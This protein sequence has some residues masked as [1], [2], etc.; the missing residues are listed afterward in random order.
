MLSPALLIFVCFLYMVFLAVVAGWAERR[1]ASGKDPCNNPIIYALSLTVY[2]TAW[3]FY[4]SVGKAASAGM[5]FL[6]IYLGPTLA[7]ILWWL[8]LR[9]MVRIKEAYRVTSIADFI[10]LRY[11][12]ST[13]V[14]ALVTVID[15]FAVIPYF[16]LQLQAMMTTFALV[17]RSAGAYWVDL[18]VGL[19]ISVLVIAFTIV[20]GVRRL[21]PTERHQ[22]MVVAMTVA[23]LVKLVPLL[24]VGGYVTYVLFGGMEDLFSRFAVSPVGAS[25]GNTQ[26]SPSSYVSWFSFLL[27]SMSAV[28]F[29][30]RQFHMAVVENMNEKHILTA[31]WLFPLYMLVMNFFLLPITMGGLLAGFPVPEADSFVLL[32]P[33]ANGQT[34]LS[35]LAFVGGV[36]AATGMIMVGSMTVSTM[37]A[38]HLMLPV[39]ESLP[40]LAIVK[41]Y[42]LQCRWLSVSF[43]VLA[44]YWF[45]GVVGKYL[46]LVDIGILS[47]AAIL[48]YAPAMVGALF[49][50]KGNKAGALLGM[51]AGFLL[52]FY[53]LIVPALTR[54][55]VLPTSILQDGPWGVA[56]LRPEQLFGLSGFDPASHATLWTMLFNVSLYVLGSLYF[57]Q[58]VEERNVAEQFVTILGAASIA[59]PRSGEATVD[60]A[61]KSDEIAELYCQYFPKEKAE[62]LMTQSLRDLELENKES[63]SLAELAELY[64][65]AEIRLAG[66]IGAAAAYNAF[67]KSRIISP[68]EQKTLQ[69]VY[70]DILS[71]LR[72]APS[73]LKKRVDYHREREKLL[74]QQ[75]V[76]LEEK[77]RER[78]REIVQRTTAEEALRESER[79]L[80]V[81]IDF[82]PDPT[83]VV[84]AEGRIIVW[85]RAAEEFSGAKAENMLGKGEREYS[86]PFYGDRRPLLLD[87]ILHP[88]EAEEIKRLYLRVAFEGDKVIGEGAVRSV[89]RGTAYTMGLAAPLYDPEGRVIAAIESVRDITELKEAE[90][91]LKRHRANLEEL[92]RERTAELMEAK[93]RAEVAS[94]AKSAFLSSMSHELR[95]PL[96]AVLGYVQILRRH[97]N[98]TETQRQQL[99][100]VR[101]SGE[102]LLS[103]INDILDMGKI[104]AQ[105][106]ELEEL[107]FELS[108]L[109]AQVVNIGKVR[110]EEKELLFLYQELTPLPPFVRGDQRKLKQILLNLVSNAVKYTH[111]GGVTIRVSYQTPEGT[112]IC[113]VED[114]GI[115]IAADKLETIFEPF[116]QLVEPGH[117]REGTG[118]GLS[119]TK[120]LV[121]LMHGSLTVESE[122]GKGSTFRLELPLPSVSVGGALVDATGEK[123][124]GY[125]GRRRRIL[126]VEDNRT[127]ASLLVALLEPLGFQMETAQDGREALRMA[128]ELHPDLVLL[129]LVMPDMDG[130]ETVREMRRL[131]VLRGTVIIGTSATVTESAKK[132]EFMEA[133]DDFV[134]KPVPLDLLLEKIG[135]QLQ[136]V[137]ER[138]LPA[139]QGAARPEAQKI[140]GALLTPPLE[141]LAALHALALM[142][143]MQGIRNWAADLEEKDSRYSA[144]TGVLRDLAGRF[145]AKAILFLVEEEMKRKV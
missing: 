36:A 118:L 137:W 22:G 2:H 27:L 81:I 54:G 48:Q 145:K 131:D 79:R 64:N 63:I 92:V 128:V 110:A 86:V 112:F 38:N 72:M 119:I 24:A 103:L 3:S 44:G 26:A 23:S 59:V 39:I 17:S 85:N 6:T 73:E 74:S 97:D 141:E 55:G 35:V 42:M 108:A 130:L 83:F 57:P 106:M 136:L 121:T 14:A 20:V 120:R 66:S 4:G 98:L 105:K 78:D 7:V 89:K 114:T 127:N 77:I 21:A 62:T 101:G 90:E 104:E 1:A 46:I 52:W 75:A 18:N 51:G 116:V 33:L 58:K 9:K 34:L 133:C 69:Q 15:I 47:F 94:Q 142:G 67:Q 45:Q 117:S 139:A 30:P 93:N 50:K 144:F 70:A 91:E 19:V 12:K 49:W 8:I 76:E 5:L 122:P 102:H 111:R 143:D 87:I 60:L 80:A 115:G 96:N 88:Q 95:T 37:V 11:G 107:A 41:Q 109:L 65:D 13:A 61:A 126:V 140:E 40:R 113:A 123:I 10:S 32:L 29:M 25:L 134:A 99:E 124:T 84:D 71:E 28:M 43:L 82:L 53:T 125:Q 129:D 132:E 68:S 100:I 31:M 138:A 16:S 56:A 135:V